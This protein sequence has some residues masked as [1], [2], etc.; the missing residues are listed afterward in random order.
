MRTARSACRSAVVRRNRRESV[1]DR[2]AAG[3]LLAHA[4]SGRRFAPSMRRRV[5]QRRRSIGPPAWQDVRTPP[6]TSCGAGDWFKK[7]AETNSFL[8]RRNAGYVKL[9][10]LS[11]PDDFSGGAVPRQ[12]AN[13]NGADSGTICA[14]AALR[15]K[16]Q[17]RHITRPARCNFPDGVPRQ[18]QPEI[19][20]RADHAP[21]RSR[22]GPTRHQ[23]LPLRPR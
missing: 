5:L 23:A 22:T 18:Q 4:V 14:R 1:R 12:S 9:N 10:G 8:H 13:H 15:I 19:Q 2:P 16:F 7:Q 20:H 21:C 11:G 17:R 6:I 3:I